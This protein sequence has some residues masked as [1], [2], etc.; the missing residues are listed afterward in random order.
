VGVED[1][2]PWGASVWPLYARDYLLP[3]GI[4]SAVT[5]LLRDGDRIVAAIDLLR[6]LGAGHFRREELSV[7]R[8]CQPLLESAHRYARGRPAS[9]RPVGGALTS[10][11]K[12]VARLALTGASTDEIARALLIGRATA[13][14]HLVRI[15][16]KLG[17]HS[18]I[19]LVHALG[20]D[21]LDGRAA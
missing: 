15:Y 12:D 4:G 7:L 9:K 13:K 17:V 5:V 20:R 2:G 14:T 8:R 3:L 21:E 11:E 1:L 16:A 19:Q 18:R 10:R 6:E